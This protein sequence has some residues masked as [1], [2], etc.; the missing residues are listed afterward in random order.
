MALPATIFG[1]S[2]W[3]EPGFVYEREASRRARQSKAWMRRRA[4]ELHIDE[5]REDEDSA[6]RKYDRNHPKPKGCP[7][8]AG[9]KIFSEAG[10]LAETVASRISGQQQSV[11]ESLY[12][13][14][15]LTSKAVRAGSCRVFARR[16]DSLHEDGCLF[17]DKQF[18]TFFRCGLRYCPGGCGERAFAKLFHKHMRLAQIIAAVGERARDARG[19]VVVAK[20]DFT[21]R[22]KA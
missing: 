2:N 21:S 22:K 9:P 20:L 4:S 13:E 8:R 11:A 3:H 17:V 12:H 18:F 1:E 6:T 19:S 14:H 16:I 5:R 15:G 10:E 7:E